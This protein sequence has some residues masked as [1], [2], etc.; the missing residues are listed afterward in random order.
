MYISVLIC[1]V[2]SNFY[3]DYIAISN[4]EH[5]FSKL[6][7]DEWNQLRINKSINTETNINC[8]FFIYTLHTMTELHYNV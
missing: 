6:Y 3:S 2:F 1:L 8:I 7:S 4:F 5:V